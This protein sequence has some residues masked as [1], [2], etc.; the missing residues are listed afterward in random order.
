VAYRVTWSDTADANLH[1][2]ISYIKDDSPHHAEVVRRNLLAATA[3]LADFP[4][5]GRM[6]PENRDPDAREI[7]VYSYRV[8]YYVS[9]GLVTI[10]K[11]LHERQGTN[12]F[13]PRN[14]DA[15]S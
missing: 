4:Y 6:I 10:H 15:T 1:S 13:A 3:R 14:R 8:M 9:P 7:F 11:I 5:S 2:I 12:D